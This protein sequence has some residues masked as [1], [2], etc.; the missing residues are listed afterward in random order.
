LLEG[1][2]FGHAAIVAYLAIELKRQPRVSFQ[3]DSSLGTARRRA[4]PQPQRLAN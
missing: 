4:S 2:F 3:N 1:F